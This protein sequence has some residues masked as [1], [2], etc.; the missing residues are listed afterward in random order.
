M[1]KLLIIAKRDYIESVKTKAFLFGLIVTPILFGSGFIGIM[2]MEKKPDIAERRI[3]LVDRTGE[4]AA[5]V[6]EAVREK[7][8][9]DLNDKDTGTQT[10][11]RYKFEIVAP[12][13][14]NPDA[15][16]L[17]LSRRVSSKDLY[18]F[19]EIG[20]KALHPDAEGEKNPENGISWYSNETGVNG[21]RSWINSPLND[22]I[23]RVRMKQSGVDPARFSDL[24]GSVDIRTMNLVSRDEKTGRIQPAQKR[25]QAAMVVPLVMVMM[26]FMIVMITSAPM[27]NAIAEDKLQRVHEMLL[28]S[29][30]PFDLIGGKVLAAVGR[31]LTSS[32]VYIAGALVALNALAMFGIAPLEM[33]PWFLI[34]LI[35]EITMLSAI[36]AA[37]GSACGSPQD[38]Q[39]LGMLLF[40]PVIIPMMMLAPLMEAPNGGLAV[41]MSF[42]PPFTPMMMMLRQA[43]PGGIPAWQPWVG[44]VGMVVG[45]TVISWAAS[46]I[47][48]VG[49]LL[50]GKP[51][52]AAELLKWAVRG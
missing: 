51:P 6:I 33:I 20:S 19:A 3:A 30:T 2:V 5:T 21:G 24:L 38:A 42:F 1:N 50:Q 26:L 36:A 37:L 39:S 52:N 46:R 13:T 28:A 14:A 48:R 7:N 27:L 4:A 29:V 17:A 32:I 31:S 25:N 10:M 9:L 45:V 34:Y 15:Q 44:L 47:F 16:R 22:G 41:A 43:M 12:D 23:R 8:E 18:A 35:A 11:P 49:I 40:V